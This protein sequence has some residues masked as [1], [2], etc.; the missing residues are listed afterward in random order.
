MELVGARGG[1][2]GGGGPGI[3][4]TTAPVAATPSVAGTVAPVAPVAPD[5]MTAGLKMI[6]QGLGGTSSGDENTAAPVQSVGAPISAGSGG[7]DLSA[8]AA[9]LMASLLDSRRKRYGLSLTGMPNG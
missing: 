8:G 9:A 6:Q 5:P 2:R 4:L 1:A 3:S 7:Q